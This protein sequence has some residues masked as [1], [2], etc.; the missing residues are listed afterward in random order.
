LKLKSIKWWAFGT[1]F[2][3]L[4]SLAYGTIAEKIYDREFALG[5]IY[6]AWW[7]VCL[8]A[9]LGITSFIYIFKRKL[10]LKRPV[11][12]LHCAFGIIL[13]G[14]GITFLTAGRGYIHLR[15]GE[16]I[17]AYVSEE[18]MTILPL[19]FKIR[20]D[21]FDIEYHPGTKEAANYISTLK[22]AGEICH[23]SMN[24]IYSYRGYRLYQTGYDLDGKGSVLWV[25]HDPWGIGISYTGYFLLF[26]SMS[27]L[28][29][30]RIGWKFLLCIMMP[31]ACLWYYISLLNPMT[32]ILRSPMLA[33][34][35]SVIV[36]SYILL[37][38]I[39]ITGIIGL[40]VQK[41]SKRLYRWNLLILYPA[42]LVSG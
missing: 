38:I 42:S 31:V 30:I 13:L 4:V 40:C 22:I 21:S 3:I 24:N 41:L 17:Q 36:I 26:L 15:E 12:L 39:T 9:I 23:I 28:L 27:W 16:T 14:A 29:L 34:H 10:Y 20:L 7:F 35:V 18:D 19:P 6:E 11:F 8:W 2:V 1:L 25:N 37:A 32:P 33:A 5:Q